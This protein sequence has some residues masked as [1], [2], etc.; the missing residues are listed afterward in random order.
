MAEAQADAL[1]LAAANAAAAGVRA[2]TEA[3]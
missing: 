1:K 3:W 2:I